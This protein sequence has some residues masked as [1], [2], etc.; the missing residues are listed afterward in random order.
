MSEQINDHV[1]AAE[2]FK[3]YQMGFSYGAANRPQLA[4]YVEHEHSHVVQA[5]KDGYDV[6]QSHRKTVLL[7]AAKHYGYDL[8]P[9]R[10]TPTGWP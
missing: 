10:R 9:P 4:M 3:S 5:Y 2:L 6:G 1:R 7:E 8:G